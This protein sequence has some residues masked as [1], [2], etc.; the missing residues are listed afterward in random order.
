MARGTVDK[1]KS[2]KWVEVLAPK[3]FNS[4]VICQTIATDTRNIVG[5]TINIGL[6][7]VTGDSGP[8]QSLKLK[9]K[10]DAMRGNQA[11]TK[12]MGYAIPE[13]YLRTMTRKMSTKIYINQAVKSRDN[14]VFTI[15]SSIIVN[16]KAPRTTKTMLMK[17]FRELIIAEA[18][19]T[20]F[21]DLISGLMGNRIAITM[22][23]ELHKI[24][25]VKQVVIEKTEIS[26]SVKLP[27]EPMSRIRDRRRPDDRREV[28]RERP[29]KEEAPVKEEEKKENAPKAE[30]KKE[31]EEKEKPKEEEKPAEK[32]E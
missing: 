2:K 28:R 15:K 32:E 5:R 10:I 21:T 17:K 12:F 29:A 23:K 22:K 8:R 4:R 19:S 25:P 16:R 14:T 24:Y 18:S 26:E 7:E 27:D 30:E 9:F 13:S 6:D 11:V 1:W 31:P 3:M 20:R